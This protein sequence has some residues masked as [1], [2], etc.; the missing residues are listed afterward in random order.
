MTTRH[1]RVL[2]RFRAPLPHSF[3]PPINDLEG[4]IGTNTAPLNGAG[5][6]RA[7]QA[8]ASITVRPPRAASMAA[9]PVRAALRSRTRASPCPG[10][11]AVASLLQLRMILP[12]R[13]RFT[14]QKPILVRS[15]WVPSWTPFSFSGSG[16]SAM[17]RRDQDLLLD[18]VSQLRVIH[19]NWRAFS[20][21]A[22]LVIPIE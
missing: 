3:K 22:Q 8:R 16:S 1:L 19:R 7:Q 2:I 4:Q 5:Q 18:L 20:T 11:G 17:P 10:E 6:F 9:E 15:T 21:L 14:T 13:A 12:D